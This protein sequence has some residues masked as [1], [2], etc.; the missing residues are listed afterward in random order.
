VRVTIIDYGAGNVPS[1]ERALQ[2]LGAESHRTDSPESISK[3]KA[4]LLPGVGHYSALVRALDEQEMREPLLGAIQRG[5]PFLGICLGLQV[6]FDSSAESPQLRGLNLLPGKV[7][8][9]P[10]T[11]KLPHMG[12]NQITPN[13]ESPL[14]AGIDA[15]AY[16]YFA[17]S[18]AAPDSN[19]ATATCFYGAAFAAVV[20]QQNIF[21]VQFH[22]E[23]SGDA[24]S[25][26]LQNFLRLAA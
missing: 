26:L 17:H 4:L 6:L 16:F 25:R 12:W 15:S 22:P 19:G 9:L 1:V 14:L 7:C 2:R 18:F 23:K 8:A 11:V 21:G 20:E 5:V 3:A 13:R 10:P 24:G